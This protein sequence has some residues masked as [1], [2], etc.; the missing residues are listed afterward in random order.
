LNAGLA[1]GGP[2]ALSENLSYR[3]TLRKDYSDG[4]RKNLYSGK[5][6]TS[7]KDESTFRLKVNWEIDD[8]TIIKFLITQIDLDDPCRYL[9]N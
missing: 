1:F 5:S 9:D 2:T 4:F 7:K 8:E 6:N 3:L